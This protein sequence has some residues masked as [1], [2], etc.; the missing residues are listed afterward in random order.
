MPNTHLH[1]PEDLILSGDLTVLTDLYGEL[2]VTAKID[3]CPSIVW[4]PH[5]ETKQFFVSTKSAFNKK[6]FKFCYTLD[7]IRHHFSGQQNLIDILWS[8]LRNLPRTDKIYQGD[9]IGLGGDIIYTPNTLTYEFPTRVKQHLVIAPHTYYT[10]DY[11][12]TADPHP[13]TEQLESTKTVLFVQPTVDRVP[14]KMNSFAITGVKGL[15]PKEHAEAMKQINKLIRDGVPLLRGTLLPILKDDILV[16]M[17]LFTVM[18]KQEVMKNLIVYDSPK[19]Y[20]PSGERVPAEGF[21]VTTPSGRMF[22]LV[23]RT[24]FSVHNFNNGR[25]S[26]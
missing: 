14:L 17:F 7:D 20:L 10:G 18:A 21:V 16:D 12:P 4:G 26:S 23:D 9:V 25:F 19:C 2:T 6:K 13:L 15:A 3:G 1:H 8:A 5:P 11:L 24:K 22:K